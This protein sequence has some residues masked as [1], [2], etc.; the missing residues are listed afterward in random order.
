MFKLV[1]QLA[2]LYM[3]SE[4]PIGT[5][6]TQIRATDKD[7]GPGGHLSYSIDSIIGSTTA[8]NSDKYACEN[9]LNSVFI[10]EQDIGVITTASQLASMCLYTISITAKDHGIPSLSNVTVIRVQTSFRNY[11]SKIY[12]PSVAFLSQMGK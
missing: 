6:V 8:N 9:H 11:T 7:S 5:F 2:V 12:P 1:L 10:I 4:T 3:S